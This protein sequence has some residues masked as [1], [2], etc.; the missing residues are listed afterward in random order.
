MTREKA[1][2]V[3]SALDAIVNFEEFVAEIEEMIN[4]TEDFTPLSLDFKVKLKC[5]LQ[6]EQL[7]LENVLEEM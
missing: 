7:R 6:T 3:C 5:L 4:K 1:L 2:E